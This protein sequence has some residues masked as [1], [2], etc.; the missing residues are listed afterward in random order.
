VY[1]S[2]ITQARAVKA[3][4][5][6]LRAH[7]FRNSGVLFWQFNDCCPA[8]SWSAI[9][10]TKRP[11]AL[12]YYAKR[13]FSNLMITA[14]PELAKTKTD[15]PPKLKSLNIIA[16]NDSNQ[17]L[18]AT[19]NCRLIDLFGHLLD[20]VAFP[21]AIGPFSISTPLKLPKAI[22]FPTHPDKSCLHLLM[23]KEGK[24]I[25]ENLFFYLPDK[26]IDWPKVEITRQFSQITEKQWKLKL[27]SNAIA[28]DVQ[29]S[30]TLPAQLIDNFIDLLPNCNYEITINFDRQPPSP[31]N[32][33]HLNFVKYT[34]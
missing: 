10:Y 27:K 18:T 24:E 26:Y 33:V 22:V 14:I 13:F 6:H 20:Q 16:I 28:K 34:S 31:E 2:Q 15:S 21:I 8:I 9:D 19:L 32:A 3:Y 5:E 17:P 30:T 25:A 23:D 4:V 1:L 12:S 11:K 29:I 7:N